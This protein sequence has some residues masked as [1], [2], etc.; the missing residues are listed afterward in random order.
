MSKTPELKIE[1]LATTALQ[2][3]EG[4]ARQHGEIDIKAIK[5]SIEEFGFNDPIGIWGE[6]VIVEG[7]GRLEAAKQLGMTEV[8]CIRLDHMTDEERRAYAIAH[9]KTAELSAWNFQKLD[10]ELLGIK[11]IDMSK[12]G[13]QVI[14]SEEEAEDDDYF[15]DLPK[16]PTTKLG[17]VYE[18]GEHILVC[19]D[20][21][22]PEVVKEATWGGAMQA[23]LLLTDPPYNVALGHHMRP[24]EAIQL[25]RR[26]D[27]LV[28]ENDDM[29]EEGFREF[30][31][32]ALA[33]AKSR[34][35]PGAAFYIWHADNN[36]LIFRQTCREAGF[37]I[38]QNLIWVKNT[39]AMGRQD[40][41]WRHE[42]CLY[43]WKEG[44]AHYF[45]DDRTQSTVYEDAR[46]NFAT[47][48]KEEMR[49]LL[50]NIYADKESTTVLHEKKPT[51]S[52]LHPTMKPVTLIAR[53]IKN[54]TRKGDIVLDPFGGSGTTLITCE[55][56]KRKCAMVELD[57]HYCD[58]IIDRWETLTGGKAKRI[59]SK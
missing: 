50:E 55:Q 41:Q 8:P 48:K 7:H 45:V 53:L 32:K 12:F 21:T 27:G 24:S 52:V 6:N 47:M 2:E 23:D 26:T 51:A 1:M 11:S 54:S 46:P 19:G 44:A 3:Y 20:S 28:I 29:D 34:M 22:D 15:V 59:K 14:E 40:Y 18:L 33:A 58:V 31:R 39:F 35:R 43:G 42:P 57:P 9:N 36:S 17:D 5:A 56:L 49:E 25:R 30:L 10:I 4:N 38:R 37:D 13:L 16:I